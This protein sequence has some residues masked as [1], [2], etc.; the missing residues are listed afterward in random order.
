MKRITLLLV[1]DHTVVRQ[2]VLK[3]LELEPDL[4]LVGKA[5][6]GCQAVELASKLL[7]DGV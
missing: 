2:G 5:Q 3:V 1:E 6:D 4:A 7:P